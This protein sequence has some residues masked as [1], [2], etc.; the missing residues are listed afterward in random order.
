MHISNTI[1]KPAK[2]AKVIHIK[3]EFLAVALVLGT[4][5]LVGGMLENERIEDV[6]AEVQK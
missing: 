6:Y 1:R 2:D 3:V 5:F 4:M